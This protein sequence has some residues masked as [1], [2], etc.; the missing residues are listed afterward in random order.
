MS[1]FEVAIET[2]IEHEGGL[3][4]HPSD[5]GGVTNYGISLRWALQAQNEG[6]EA[7]LL[8]DMDGDGDV[9]RDDIRLMSLDR[10]KAVYR[11]QWWDKNQYQKLFYQSVATKV[12]DTA[13]NVGARQAHKF[14]QRAMR[15]TGRPLM[16]DGMIGP[17][18]LRAV[19][20]EDPKRV[21]TG[22]RSEQAGFY[23]ALIM[24][25]NALLKRNFDVPDFSA[26]KTGWFRR[27]YS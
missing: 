6:E 11:L 18:T 27:A 17:T 12:F 3:I 14:L 2:V 21:M 15:A 20:D 22:L 7:K 16:D 19:N 24:R 9:D 10:A 4:D 1:S 13:I 8:L 23:R 26:F 5:P 25:N